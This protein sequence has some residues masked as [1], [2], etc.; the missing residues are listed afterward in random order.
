MSNFS[1]P[2]ILSFS[3]LSRSVSNLKS[4]ADTTRTETV[5]GRFEDLTT[6]L[7]GDIGGAQLLQKAVDD[8]KARHELLTLAERRAEV[9]QNALNNVASESNE[10]A[11]QAL[12]AF[13]RGDES[14]L[15]IT[16]SQARDALNGVFS[17]LNTSFAGR[18]LFSGDATE[19]SPLV[20]PDQLLSDVESILAGAADAADAQNQLDVYFNDPAGGFATSIYQGGAGRAAS[21]EISPGVR[22][23]PWAKAD[24]PEIRA[25]IRGL[26]E[27]AAYQSAGF[28]DAETIVEIGA[29]RTLKAESDLAVVRA[30]IGINESRIAAAKERA[31]KEE[32]ILTKLFNDK[33]ARDPF[34]AAAE[35]QLL[36]SQL[37]KS[38]LLTAR[39]ARLSIADFIR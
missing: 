22:I 38:F 23:D 36:E 5:T 2:D 29:N 7:K 12:A 35:L 6:H 10:L 4:R 14:Q 19:R 34:E 15:K 28:S 32:E 31:Q 17:A 8:A 1:V 18:A 25:L 26:A 13:K 20:S 11:A 27:M 9:T 21:V 37:E 16:S 33:T 3:Q 30:N 24:D 39:L